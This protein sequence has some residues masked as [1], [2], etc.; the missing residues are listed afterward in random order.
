MSDSTKTLVPLPEHS[1][2][3]VES[4]SY[5]PGVDDSR[6]PFDFFKQHWLYVLVT[7]VAST[8]VANVALKN[9]SKE[10]FTYQG[11]LLYNRSTAG[12]PHYISP[13][14]NTLSTIMKSREVLEQLA[15]EFAVKTP[16]D[17]LANMIDVHI[18]FGGGSVEVKMTEDT[19]E[20][21]RTM[22]E[23]LMALFIA[24]A[25]EF[26]GE[27]LASYVD[28]FRGGLARRQV[29][30]ERA[31]SDM[32]DLY[33]AENIVDIEQDLLRVQEE[34]SNT[35]LALDTAKMEHET[36][37]AQLDRLTGRTSRDNDSDGSNRAAEGAM[38]SADMEKRAY[39]RDRLSE[40]RDQ[41]RL[42]AELKLKESDFRR[43]AELHKKQLISDA[44]FERTEYE[45]EAL[46]AQSD[47]RFQKLESELKIIEGRLPM[48]LFGRGRRGSLRASTLAD[49]MAEI[50]LD[51]VS[52]EGR[53]GHLS[54]YLNR[55]QAKLARLTSLRRQAEKLSAAVESANTER[56]RL[57]SLVATFDQLRQS[58]V[59]EFSVIEPA[60]P[61]LQFVQSNKKKVAVGAFVLAGFVLLA[62]ALI[63]DQLKHRQPKAAGT[64]RI[65]GIPVLAKAS[66]RHLGRLNRVRD[67][68]GSDDESSRLILR[69]R[70]QRILTSGRCILDIPKT[71]APDASYR[72]SKIGFADHR[73]KNL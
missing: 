41:A 6:N 11:V 59:G 48:E 23:R 37:N 66:S 8:I 52:A 33:E 21:A 42:A 3:E 68:D 57:E 69:R 56:S 65:L 10:T 35:K 18:P 13:D 43:A 22:L 25:E 1:M 19:P 26:R 31:K 64:A 61:G 62:P 30:C 50:E 73:G 60:S 29:V 58:D 53:V 72:K 12:S 45:L 14:L 24:K 7:I 4:P 63:I 47:G 17:A 51:I 70:D 16:A 55:K 67:D 15:A 44:E 5:V 32:L 28:D 27:S 46:R 2:T 9:F 20:R 49:T 71:R 38:L 54:K 40:E 34:I 39:L 36:L